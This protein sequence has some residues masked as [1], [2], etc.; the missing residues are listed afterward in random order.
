MTC[1]SPLKQLRIRSSCWVISTS[2]G[3]HVKRV[4]CNVADHRAELENWI[5]RFAQLHRPG[6]GDKLMM[7]IRQNRRFAIDLI[8][9]EPVPSLRMP[10]W[11]QLP[12]LVVRQLISLNGIQYLTTSLSASNSTFAE[13]QIIVDARRSAQPLHSCVSANGFS[14]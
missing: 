10:A 8:G 2:S 14:L 6:A 9:K 3:L 4:N 7:Q 5:D 11:F 13:I 1:T 12:S